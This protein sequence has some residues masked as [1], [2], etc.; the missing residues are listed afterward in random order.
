MKEALSGEKA[1]LLTLESCYRSNRFGNGGPIWEFDSDLF[2]K[3]ATELIN[4]YYGKE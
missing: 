1:F 4:A 2:Q 3:D